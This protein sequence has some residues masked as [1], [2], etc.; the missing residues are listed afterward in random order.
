MVYMDFISTLVTK[1]KQRKYFSFIKDV[2][3]AMFSSKTKL[4]V[5]ST[6]DPKPFF[7]TLKNLIAR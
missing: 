6:D 1:I 5:F 4:N 3:K 7:M 2:G